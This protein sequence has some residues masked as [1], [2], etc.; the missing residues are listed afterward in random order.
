MS[1]LELMSSNHLNSPTKNLKQQMG[2]VHLT[3][4]LTQIME[5]TRTDT[6]ELSRHTGIPVPTINRLRTDRNC[7]PTIGTLFPIASYFNLTINQLIGAEEISV[8][9]LINPS[10]LGVRLAKYIPVLTL[11]HIVNPIKLDEK[12]A[13]QLIATSAKVADDAFAIIIKGSLISSEFLE[14][15]ILVFD[16]HTSP[17]DK[18]YVIVR[19]EKNQKP[20]IRQ[21]LIDGDD[22]YFKPLNS[23]IGKT[24]L[25]R[26]YE[27]LGIMIQA[28]KNYRE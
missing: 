9:P 22:C 2:N 16:R 8:Y 1:E 18:D 23:D 12:T 10:K 3:H 14:N 26:N 21:L 6:A 24:T 11:E 25:N 15:T 27:I 19:L 28:F 20:V 7:N 13:P 5:E 17:Q 4:V